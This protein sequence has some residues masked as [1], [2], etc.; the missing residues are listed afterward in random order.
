[1]NRKALIAFLYILVFQRSMISPDSN[2]F[3]LLSDQ[4]RDWEIQI[5]AT[6]SPL[7]RLLSCVSISISLSLSPSLD[8]QPVSGFERITYFPWIFQTKGTG[9]ILIIW[10]IVFIPSTILK[11]IIN[12][13]WIF[14]SNLFSHQNSLAFL[15]PPFHYFI[16]NILFFLSY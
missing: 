14:Q 16:R 3:P 9:L 10:P 4:R 2:H 12:S 1:M 6:A 11:L 15:I 13:P 8:S 7:L 5:A